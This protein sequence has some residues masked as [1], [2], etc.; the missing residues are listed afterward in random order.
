MRVTGCL[1]P[2]PYRPLVR[3][4]IRR[5]GEKDRK[6]RKKKIRRIK[7]T[8]E[9]RKEGKKERTKERKE[10]RKGAAV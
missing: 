3:C 1:G 5:E 2:R 8:K 4:I 10:K 6:E 9:R 7:G